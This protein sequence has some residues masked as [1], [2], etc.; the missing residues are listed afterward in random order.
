MVTE[1]TDQQLCAVSGTGEF[2]RPRVQVGVTTKRVFG[3][4][5]LGMTQ[6]KVGLATPVQLSA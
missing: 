1:M 4:R 2:D 3:C 6:G 5:Q